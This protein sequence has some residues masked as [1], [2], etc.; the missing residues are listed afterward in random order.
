MLMIQKIYKVFQEKLPKEQFELS[1][2]GI[3]FLICFKDFGN[4]I[5][6]LVEENFCIVG[7]ARKTFAIHYEDMPLHVRVSRIFDIIVFLKAFAHY[8]E[9]YVIN[10]TPKYGLVKLIQG[11]K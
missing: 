6:I 3:N 8:M 9:S 7:A 5:K 4:D 11:D 2:E 1:F 10:N